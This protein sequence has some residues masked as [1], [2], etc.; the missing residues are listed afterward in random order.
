MLALR[1]EDLS[2]TKSV[3][4]DVTFEEN[5]PN[6]RILVSFFSLIWRIYYKLSYEKF[7]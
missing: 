1:K 6:S 2:L 4:N 5:F 3:D 7:C